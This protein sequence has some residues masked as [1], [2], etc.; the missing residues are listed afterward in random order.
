MTCSDAAAFR[1]GVSDGGRRNGPRAA[2]LFTAR[3]THTQRTRA[4][5][6]DTTTHKLMNAQTLQ[7]FRQ[8]QK[9]EPGSGGRKPPVCRLVSSLQAPNKHTRRLLRGCMG[10]WQQ[11]DARHVQGR[12]P[13]AQRASSQQSRSVSVPLLTNLSIQQ[14]RRRR[15]DTKE[16]ALSGKRSRF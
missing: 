1:Q 7:T 3:H 6:S 9:S 5:A 2:R 14:Q 11:K 8:P 12:N 15:A 4:P 16:R 10:V 13:P